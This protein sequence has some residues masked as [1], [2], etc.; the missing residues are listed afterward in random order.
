MTATDPVPPG[1]TPAANVT[2]RT[3]GGVIWLIATRFAGRIFD[4]V[5][6]VVMARVLVPR[7]FGL[8]ALAMTAV[9]VVEAVLEL[10]LNAALVRLPRIDQRHL[11]TAFT[12]SILRGLL[13]A[14]CLA[15]VAYP[16]ARI[17]GDPRLFPLIAALA[18]APASRG[19]ASPALAR[20]S[21]R[22]SF[23]P[24]FMMDV[25]GKL[26]ASVI[27]ITMAVT[28]RSYWALALGT[29]S[30]PLIAALISYVVAPYRPRIGLSEWR[31]FAGFA[32]WTSAAQV[33]SALN[34][35]A[36]R[37]ILGRL[38][39]VATVGR[40][41]MASDL[42]SLPEQALLKPM[43]RPIMSGMVAVRD[44]QERLRRAYRRVDRMIVTLLVPIALGLAL[45]AEPLLRIGL[46][47][48]WRSTA[49]LLS[50]FALTLI[51][52]NLGAALGS[53]AMALDRTRI[54]YRRTWQEAVVR[55]P[56][57]LG[58][59]FAFGMPGLLAGRFVAAIWTGSVAMRLIREMTGFGI[60]AQLRSIARPL[61]AGGIA[62]AVT[63][64]LLPWLSTLSGIGLI[65][66]AGAVG[67]LVVTVY[68]AVLLVALR[69]GEDTGL[70][71]HLAL[72]MLISIAR[73]GRPG[74]NPA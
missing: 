73:R 74:A 18:L 68:V 59:V 13:V 3:A 6:L 22:G 29:I 69:W 58:G 23:R 46:G 7:D 57:L 5:T 41:A 21:Q 25:G 33:L 4:L 28:T 11:D 37:L 36:D 72:E 42:S 43:M 64:P 60:A 44:D 14:S 27:A 45:L 61:L 66:A 55:I 67:A 54:M 30:A 31:D 16:Y 40:Y 19:V 26:F 32:G 65:A 15:A 62:T 8:V 71:E 34:W 38:V 39:P 10:P 56:L 52:G 63:L 48:Q 24:D 2:T 70:P 47:E 9:Y 35:Q 1:A 12:L 51:P 53:T 49:P 17:Y 20:W 50:I